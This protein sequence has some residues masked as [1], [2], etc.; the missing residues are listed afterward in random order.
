[1]PQY[2]HDRVQLRTPLG[3]LR[4]D[5][6]TEAMRADGPTALLIDSAGDFAGEFQR[7]LEEVSTREQSAVLHE[8]VSRRCSREFIGQCAL[9][10]LISL[11][12]QLPQ[13][14]CRFFM[15]RHD[16]FA[17]CFARW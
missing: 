4:T 8:Y 3:Q 17:I 1:M 10:P 2:A 5:G 15:Q 6:V 11:G 13:F 14:N 16:A 12:D 7:C 9:A